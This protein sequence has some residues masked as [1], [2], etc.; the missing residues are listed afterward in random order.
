MRL[1]GLPVRGVVGL[2]LHLEHDGDDLVALLIE[3]AED[4][5]ALGALHHLV[6]LLE[7]GAGEGGRPQ[8]QP[9][10]N[11]GSHAPKKTD[12]N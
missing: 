10:R 3:V 7:V 11:S 9:R 8:G 1:V 2:V 5:V 6:V 12:N 4:E